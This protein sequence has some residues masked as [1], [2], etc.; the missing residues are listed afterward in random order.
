MQLTATGDFKRRI[1]CTQAS[2]CTR[3]QRTDTKQSAMNYE[4][5]VQ[6]AEEEEEMWLKTFAFVGGQELHSQL[7]ESHSCR[8]LVVALLVQ[9]WPQTRSTI[10]G[11]KMHP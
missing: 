1:D 3:E 9:G 2:E 7:L 6:S 10:N 8:F 11:W 4:T 5:R